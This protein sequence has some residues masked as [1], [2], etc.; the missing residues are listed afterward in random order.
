[1]QGFNALLLQSA[2]GVFST[3]DKNIQSDFTTIKSV[4]QWKQAEKESTIA[5]SAHRKQRKQCMFNVLA[6]ELTC[7]YRKLMV[8]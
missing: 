5:I 2:L 4:Y 3:L 7:T 8:T 1:M 6:L